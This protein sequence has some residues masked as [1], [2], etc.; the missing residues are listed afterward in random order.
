MPSGRSSPLCL[1]FSLQDASVQ[2][3]GCVFDTVNGPLLDYCWTSQRLCSD[4]QGGL[5]PPTCFSNTIVWHLQTLGE[6]LLNGSGLRCHSGLFSSWGT[7]GWPPTISPCGCSARSVGNVRDD[8]SIL[9]VQGNMVVS[10]VHFPSLC[11]STECS[12]L[13]SLTEN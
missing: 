9:L 13:H 4:Q 12:G 11:C 6:S 5:Q 10:S 7:F 3:T 1:P 2:S 8:G